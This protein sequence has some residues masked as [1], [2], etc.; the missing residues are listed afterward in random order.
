M[1]RSSWR[2]ACVPISLALLCGAALAAPPP[3]DFR[4]EW[5]PA[6]KPPRTDAERAAAL[7][8]TILSKANIQM[9]VDALM[10]S[11]SISFN[12]GGKT[13]QFV[14]AAV[15]GTWRGKDGGFGRM[16]ITKDLSGVYWGSIEFRSMEFSLRDFY[17]HGVGN[18]AIL[19]EVRMSVM[20]H[21]DSAN[22]LAPRLSASARRP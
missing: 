20:S 4:G 14:G 3:P 22:E 6:S 8:A 11:D 17:F 18:T 16:E 10:A 5:D 19:F 1:T 7:Q 9:D 13:H 2:A 21:D 12:V 15:G